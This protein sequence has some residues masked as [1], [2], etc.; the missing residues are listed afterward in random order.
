MGQYYLVVNRDRQEYLHPHRLGS[1]LKL[2]EICAG[3]LPRLLAYLC[4][5]STGRGGGDPSLPCQQ[6]EDENGDV[7]WDARDA[8]IQEQFPNCGRWAGDR[9][10]IVGD[11]DESDEYGDVYHEVQDSDD[12]T[13]ISPDV[14]EEFNAFIEFEDKQVAEPNHPEECDHDDTMRTVDQSGELLHERCEDCHAVLVDRR[15]GDA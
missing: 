2:W 7:D 5:Q 14:A 8:A 9:I 12:W 1:G 10:V 15:G 3:N 4:K 6:F 11:Y 13:E